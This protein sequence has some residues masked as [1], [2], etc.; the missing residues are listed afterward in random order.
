MLTAM[1]EHEA[2]FWDENQ[3]KSLFLLVIH[4]HLYSFAFEIAISS[5]SHNLL[6]FL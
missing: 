6:Q 4:S 3:T 2:E 1:Q 5:N